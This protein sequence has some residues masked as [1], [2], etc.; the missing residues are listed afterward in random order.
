MKRK[1][2]VIVGPTASGKSALA[3]TLAKKIKGEVISADSRQVYKGLDIGS[4]KITHKEMAGI[5]H[6]LL[7]VYNPKKVYTVADF[8]KD[9]EAKID[10]ICARGNVPI[11]CGGTGFYIQAVVDNV[12]F[13]EVAANAALRAKLEKKS[14]ESL[15]AELLK[16]DPERA[17][18]IDRHNKVRVIRA[19]EIVAALGK[20]PLAN[21]APQFEVLQIGITIPDA[22]LQ[23]KIAKRLTARLKQGMLAEARKL[24]KA[25]LSWKRMEALGLEYRYMARHLQGKITRAEM[26]KNLQTEIWHYAKRQM[27]WFKKDSRIVWLSPKEVTK[28]KN[29]AERFLK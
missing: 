23:Q 20:V 28:I 27:T 25:G 26:I 12:V 11:L 24:H 10:E 8:K 2:I 29:L 17:A 4:G 16:K 3:V 9:A 22:T 15:F 6:H 5:P 19:L 18:T 7:S 14:V 1:I 13:P 21:K